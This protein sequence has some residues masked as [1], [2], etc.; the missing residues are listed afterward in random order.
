MRPRPAPLLPLALAFVSGV[1]LS[2]HLSFL[3]IP[4]LTSL[5]VVSFL[6]G[7]RAGALSRVLPWVTAFALGL[8][9][10]AV[11]EDLPQTVDP[12]WRP[13]RPVTAVTEVEGPWRSSPYGWSARVE[14]GRLRQVAGSPETRRPRVE[15]VR[16]PA[17]LHLPADAPPPPPGSRLRVRGFLQRSLGLW[18]GEPPEPGPWRLS[19]PSRRFLQIERAP[20]AVAGLSQ[21]LRRR[22]ER[23]FEELGQPDSPG[24][25]LARA[26]V[27]GDPSRLAPRTL[28]GLRRSGLG[29]LLALSGLH[30]GLM[31]GFAW[32]LGIGLRVP[33]HGRLLLVLA[34]VAL[35]LAI[36]GPRPSLLRAAVL[37]AAGVVALTLER[38]PSAAN[39]L[40]LAM[41]GLVAHRPS[42]VG[43][44]GFQLTVA[45]TWGILVLTPWWLGEEP[46]R[47]R[48]RLVMRSLAVSLG[49]QIATLPWAI[50]AFHGVSPL[51]PLLNL[52]AIPWIT[53]GLAV[54]LVWVA[55]ALIA[56]GLATALQPGLD[57]LARPLAWPALAPAGPAWFLPLDL[58]VSAAGALAVG[59]A[60]LLALPVRWSRGDRSSACSLLGAAVLVLS[61]AGALAQVGGEA[62][63]SNPRLVMLDVGQ[64]DAVLI[65][66][67]AHAVLVDGGG[68]SGGLDAGGGIGS[69]VLLPALLRLGVRRLDAVVLTHP[70]RDHCGGLV[71]IGSWLP[72]E[73]VWMAPGWR[74]DPC[75]DAL[76]ATPGVV[77]REIAAGGRGRIGRWRWLALHPEWTAEDADGGV[78]GRERRNAGSLVLAL[79]T[80]GSADRR[81]GRAGC[82][83]MRVL[84]TGD[85]DAAAEAELLRRLRGPARRLLR[86]DVL[87]VAHHGSKGSSG[88]PFLT[89]VLGPR[90]RDPP[91]LGRRAVALISAGSG[92]PYGHPAQET[93]DRLDRWR[94]RVLR[95]DRD[96]QVELSAPRA[97]GTLTSCP[98]PSSP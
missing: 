31:A 52:V 66:D 40:A 16:M 76:L 29:H 17:F 69:R 35:Y 13:R 89:A 49:A 12:G 38:P 1:G 22:V 79:S 45:A 71:E 80:E 74:G 6:R 55:V 97:A 72:V 88:L 46:W 33:R 14:I 50:P 58:S 32:W 44:L 65:Q 15:R 26:L 37:V 87:K 5:L 25:A 41:L 36:A 59:L 43:D 86:A 95:T 28:R 61:V 8:V 70:D 27:L 47:G 67:G 63:D 93:L 96:G 73:E 77:H 90:P 78:G 21:I 64:G 39:A 3:P 91:P 92:N 4:L 9:W 48:G 7:R 51:A 98:G 83:E 56:P 84:L 75:A 85:L 20:G 82:R 18:N 42:L 24:I 57:A 11:V 34:S 53:V 23:A 54:S 62:P 10:S 30:V 2:F 60:V 94:A 68:F 81:G 19:V